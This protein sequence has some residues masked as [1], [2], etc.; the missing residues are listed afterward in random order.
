MKFKAFVDFKVIKPAKNDTSACGKFLFILDL[1][2]AEQ[3]S[4]PCF[5]FVSYS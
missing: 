3:E 1:K 4:V 2:Y 5:A